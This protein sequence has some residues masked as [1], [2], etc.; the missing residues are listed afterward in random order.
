MEVRLHNGMSSI[1][2]VA[3][4]DLAAANPT[5]LLT[6]EWLYHLESSGSIV[7]ENGWHPVHMT[8]H[9]N[10]AM[11]AAVPLYLRTDSWGEF[12][13][14]FAF[15]EVAQQLGKTYYPKLVGMSPASPVP[16]FRFLTASGRED[17]LVPQIMD[18]IRSFCRTRD[19]PV[20]QF[21]FVLPE[22]TRRLERLGMQ[23]WKHH[24]FEWHNDG[25]ATFD[26]YLQ[27][28]R[29][30]QR[31]NIR[32]ERRSLQSQGIRTRVIHGPEAPPIIY[33]R[34]S[35]YY[36][37]TNSLFGPY[38]AQFLDTRFF[39]DMPR[40]VQEHVWFVAAYEDDSDNP[41]DP[42][43]LAL[44]VR[45]N[46]RIYGR[47]WGTREDRKDLHF[48]VCYYA[49]IEWAIREKISLFDPGMGSPHKVRRGFRSVSDWSLHYFF[50]PHM[51][52]ILEANMDRIN[53]LEDRQITVMDGAV[54]FKNLPP[55]DR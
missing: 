52:A 22:W 2:P 1:D 49:P 14:D 44:L 19:I 45:R 35:E 13:F 11:V 29:K 21:N 17:D 25:Y 55:V 53:T 40:A 32:R 47:Y 41:D 33:R 12:V 26:D 3:W 54:P 16:A 51:Q 34:M 18:S 48:N 7:P 15:A 31:R 9:E 28:F 4:N 8:F 10:G 43:A 5:P 20:L 6:W 42:L 23:P 50:D 27:R 30:N 36:L 39:T 46:D 37:R 38:A 24:G